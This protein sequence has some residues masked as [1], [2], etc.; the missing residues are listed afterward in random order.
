MSD[1]CEAISESEDWSVTL[2]TDFSTH[3]P[4]METQGSKGV[5]YEL[6]HCRISREAAIQVREDW[7]RGGTHPDDII[8]WMI[9]SEEELSK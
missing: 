1:V 2:R 9:A 7:V 4:Y 5:W 8:I 3:K 6:P